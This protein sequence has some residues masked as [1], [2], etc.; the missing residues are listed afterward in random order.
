M[1]GPID[2]LATLLGFNATNQ[3]GVP[4]AL[5]IGTRIL[6][7]IGATVAYNS[8][9]GAVD[10][11]F[12]TAS[13]TPQAA[14]AKSSSFSVDSPAVNMTFAISTSSAPVVSTITGTP[15]DGVE[16]TYVDVTKLWPTYKL[17]F[18]CQ[19]GATSRN[20]ENLEAA[21]TSSQ[22]NVGNVAGECFTIK[23]YADS[24]KWIPK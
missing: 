12:P 24:G 23:W 16:L 1:S 19:A 18:Q 13:N 3:S 15:V 22:V 2:W 7:F 21:D 8:T 9:T 11:T 14:V 5:P 20:P 4:V 6:N 17:G 10:V